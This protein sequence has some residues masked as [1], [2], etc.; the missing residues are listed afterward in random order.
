MFGSNKT[1]FP[2][3]SGLDDIDVALPKGPARSV[4]MRSTSDLWDIHSSEPHVT[5]PS[6]PGIAVP[7]PDNGFDPQSLSEDNDANILVNRAAEGLSEDRREELCEKLD[8]MY[9]NRL[10]SDLHLSHMDIGDLKEYILTHCPG[11]L[12]VYNE[13]DKDMLIKAFSLCKS[14]ETLTSQVVDHSQFPEDEKQVLLSFVSCCDAVREAMLL[15]DYQ[16]RQTL[17]GSTVSRD[18]LAIALDAFGLNEDEKKSRIHANDEFKDHKEAILLCE[19]DLDRACH[20]EISQGMLAKAL[21]NCLLQIMQ[22]LRSHELRNALSSTIKYAQQIAQGEAQK[23]AKE[24]KALLSNLKSDMLKVGVSPGL[25]KK[26]DNR[27]EEA[28]LVCRQNGTSVVIDPQNASNASRSPK[29][30]QRTLNGLKAAQSQIE[31]VLQKGLDPVA[32]TCTYAELYTI[33]CLQDCC[34]ALSMGENRLKECASNLHSALY[35]ELK[36]SNVPSVKALSANVKKAHKDL[37]SA[38]NLKTMKHLKQAKSENRISDKKLQTLTK[39][40]G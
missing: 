25:T 3:Y 38:E 5:A 4:A 26:L 17:I 24:S 29:E 20:L 14:L 30:L 13:S 27:I 32:K 9:T 6:D 40:L 31:Q 19:L 2:A 39:L 18:S 34:I 8:D 28:D 33:L 1:L 23:T 10:V 15:P 21:N 12:L 22:S 11:A 37:Q 35:N 16:I 7:Y 36:N